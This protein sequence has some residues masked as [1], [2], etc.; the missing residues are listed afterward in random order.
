MAMENLLIPI[1]YRVDETRESPGMLSGVLMAYG[2]RANDRPEMFEM[3]AFHWRADGIVI[4]EQHNRAAPIVRAQ[5]YMEGRAL[6][7]SVP[8]PNTSRGRDAATAMQGEHP[9]Y[10]GLSVEFN[11][12]RETRRGGLRVISRAFLD[13]AS[14][15]DTPAYLESKVEIREGL[16]LIVPRSVFTWL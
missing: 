12:E 16:G 8:L 10:S 15:V 2:T 5:P 11:A 9:L 14:L 3:D 4:R 1:E 7:I 13:G 6:K